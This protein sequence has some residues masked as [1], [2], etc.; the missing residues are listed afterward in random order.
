MKIWVPK[1]KG[2]VR[3]TALNKSLLWRF[4]MIRGWLRWPD[5]YCSP[6]IHEPTWFQYMKAAWYEDEPNAATMARHLW[7]RSWQLRSSQSGK[8]SRS[9][10]RS[11]CCKTPRAVT[12]TRI[13]DLS[14]QTHQHT[15]ASNKP[16]SVRRHFHIIQYLGPLLSSEPDPP[17]WLG[18]IHRM[19][20]VKLKLKHTQGGTVAIHPVSCLQIIRSRSSS[21]SNLSLASSIWL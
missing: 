12:C 20:H 4:R 15:P 11:Q 18:G 14:Y 21:Q 8:T 16:S 7:K 6:S 13:P 9:K 1:Q 5:L 17:A 19:E 2:P 10:E 3:C